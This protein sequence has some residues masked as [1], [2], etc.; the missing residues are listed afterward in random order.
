VQVSC[1][2]FPSFMGMFAELTG[3]SRLMPAGSALRSYKM[4][5]WQHDSEREVDQPEGACLLIRKELFEQIGLFD[6]D[7]F[8]LFEEVDWLYT[9]KKADWQIWFTPRAQVV[10]HM[11]QAIRQ[12]KEKMILSSHKGMYRYWYKHHRNGKWYWDATIYGALMALAYLRI[13]SYRLFLTLS[14]N[15]R[16]MPGSSL[17]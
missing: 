9:A 11:G 10:H 8:M 17:R 14:Q 5:D 2:A 6:E 16:K 13:A 3:I 12:V 4:L 1:R 7:Y 15:H